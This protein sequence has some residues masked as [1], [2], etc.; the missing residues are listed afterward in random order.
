M[1]DN[2]TPLVLRP[3]KLFA[4]YERRA[5]QTFVKNFK[6]VGY[7]LMAD[8]FE[9]FMPPKTQKWEPEAINIKLRVT[10]GWDDIGDDHK[11]NMTV[12]YRKLMRDHRAQDY[13]VR[14]YL[15][16]HGQQPRGVVTTGYKCK[17]CDYYL[18]HGEMAN[19]SHFVEDSAQ[20][21]VICTRCGLVVVGRKVDE[22]DHLRHFEDD[23]EDT[24]HYGMAANPLLSM[25]TNMRTEMAPPTNK[26]RSGFK[27]IT[28]KID[29][30]DSTYLGY[31]GSTHQAYRDDMII[32]AMDAVTKLSHLSEV[33]TQKGLENFARFRNYREH[34][35]KFNRSLMCCIGIALYDV[36]L[37]QTKYEDEVIK[38]Q[39]PWPCSACGLE[40][41]TSKD[42]EK[43][44]RDCSM[45]PRRKK[46]EAERKRIEAQTR[47]ERSWE[48]TVKRTNY[49]DFSGMKKK[50]VKKS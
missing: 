37:E 20:G 2:D 41:A 1:G 22:G 42:V 15:A 38:V 47:Q 16:Y 18:K 35:H 5:A 31:G 11:Y 45:I 33:V 12:G 9:A 43:H 30:R 49:I 46:R 32:R 4:P 50:R 19:Q 13:E 36:Y 27:N 3:P 28:R 7:V 29:S 44:R 10:I 34:V 23:T 48:L 26:E 17:D 40:Y 25:V 8:K 14:Y 6:Y 39:K 24:R 21:D